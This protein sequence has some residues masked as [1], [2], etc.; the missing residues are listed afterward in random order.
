MNTH[1]NFG[2]TNNIIAFEFNVIFGK[3][4]EPCDGFAIYMRERPGITQKEAT[5]NL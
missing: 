4:T 3:S 2:T 5:W 1:G